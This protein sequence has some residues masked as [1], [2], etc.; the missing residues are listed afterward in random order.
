M[1]WSR[2]FNYN[3]MPHMPQLRVRLHFMI[4]NIRT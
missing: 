2:T 3:E 4:L 1:Q